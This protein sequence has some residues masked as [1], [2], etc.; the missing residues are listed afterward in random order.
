MADATQDSSSTF[1]SNQGV[2]FEARRISLER[3]DPASRRRQVR[4]NE[5]EHSLVDEYTVA[6]GAGDK[7]PPII[8]RE[9]SSGTFFVI[10][11]IH[12]VEAAK[13][14]K[15]PYVDAYIIDVDV[16]R[17]RE[18]ALMSNRFHGKRTDSTEAL[19]HAAELVR[20]QGVTQ[21]YAAE[22]M[23]VS[24]KALGGL[25]RS[26][27]ASS[28]A[29]ELG[30]Q[31]FDRLPSSTRAIAAQFAPDDVFRAFAEWLATEKPTSDDARKA[32]GQVAKARSEK[33]ALERVAGLGPAE[34]KARSTNEDSPHRKFGRGCGLVMGVD[35]GLF[36]AHVSGLGSDERQEVD[37]KLR[38]LVLHVEAMRDAVA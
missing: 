31:G 24:L 13:A 15:R 21:K 11:G 14:N 10:D 3:I 35:V 6:M 20:T 33:S 27:E 26:Q 8:V 12:R 9:T 5:V 22:K 38:R 30:V 25:L 18:L 1:L 23:R 37:R 17:G 32:A 2:P 16:E 4:T 19:Q 7:F 36:A 28:R 34:K 29:F